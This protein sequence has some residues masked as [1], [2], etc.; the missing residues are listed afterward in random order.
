MATY[1]STL[2]W[3]MPWMEEPGGLQSMGSLRVGHDRVT[4]LSL[5]KSSNQPSFH[6]GIEKRAL[7]LLLVGQM[8]AIHLGTTWRARQRKHP[9]SLK[10]GTSPRPRHQAAMGAATSIHPHQGLE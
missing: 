2:A 6:K 8:L 9:D 10:T 7:F 1:S 4:S 5:S 3:K